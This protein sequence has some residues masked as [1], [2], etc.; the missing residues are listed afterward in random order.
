MTPETVA[1]LRSFHRT[2][3]ERVGALDARYLGRGRPL[4]EIGLD[5]TEV[6]ELR[7][8]LG[9]DSGYVSRLLRSL[10]A[11]GLVSVGGSSADARVRVARLTARGRR[12]RAQLDRLSDE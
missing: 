4:G 2:V 6:R 12:E 10:E 9:L 7:R 5:G 3:T 1:R 11:N 8:R